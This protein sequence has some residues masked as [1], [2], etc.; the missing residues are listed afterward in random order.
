MYTLIYIGIYVYV[1]ITKKPFFLTASEGLFVNEHGASR[2]LLVKANR[3][4]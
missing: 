1:C 2:C 4:F 3:R